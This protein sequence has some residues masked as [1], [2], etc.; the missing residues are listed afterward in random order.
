MNAIRSLLL[1]PLAASIATA[2][3]ITVLSED[4]SALTSGD[5]VTTTGAGTTWS[6][7]SNFPLVTRA[8]EAG[9]AV[10]IGTGSANGSITSLPLDLSINGG[11][12]HVSFAVKGWTTVEGDITVTVSGLPSQ[13]VSYTNVRVGSFETVGL[14]FTGGTAGSTI[15]FE[16]TSQRAYLDDIVVT[17][18]DGPPTPVISFDQATSSATESDGTLQI[19]VT[20]SI[21]GDA[22]VD[23]AVTGGDAT[24]PGDYTLL[25][26]SL[27]FSAGSPT[28]NVSLSLNDDSTPESTETIELTLSSP[29]GASLGATTHTVTVADDDSAPPSGETLVIVSANTT[30]G[31]NQQYEGP[32]DRIFQALDPD[33]VGIQEFNVPDPGGLRAWV[34]RVFGTEFHYSIEGG[35]EN[36]PCGVVS[37][38]PITASG[39]WQDP[40]VSD[41]D[42]AW[43]TIDIPGETDLHVISVH[44]HGGGG[45]S[46]RNIEAGVIVDQVQATFPA[47]DYI[48]LTGDFNTTSRTESCVTTFKTIF[49][50]AHTPVDQ[51]GDDDTNEPRNNPYDWVMPNTPLEALHTTFEFGGLSFP[52][53]FVFDTRLW[54][55][56]PSP[57]L[58][59]DSGASQMQHMAVVKA[60]QLPGA[61]P[62][63]TLGFDQATS[64]AS[65][66]DG[67]IKIPVTLSIPGS[68]TVDVSVTGGDAATPDDF[69]LLTPSLTFTSGNPTQSVSLSI[70]DDGDIESAETI[71]LT[72]SS[73]SGAALGSA[74][75]TVTITDNDS[76]SSGIFEDFEGGWD[77]PSYAGISTYDHAGVGIW[78]SQDS[79]TDTSAGRTGSAV[80]LR[81]ADAPYLEFKGLDGNGVDGGIGTVSFWFRHWNGTGAAV[82]FALEYNIADAGWVEAAT[83]NAS[84]DTYQQFSAT[85]DLSADNIRLRIRP[86]DSPP[87]ERLLIDDFEITAISPPP[88]VT[89]RGTPHA[90]LESFGFSGDFEAADLLDSDGD[91]FLNW[92]EYQ[93]GTDPT[94]STS[95]HRIENTGFSGGQFAVTCP[96][97]PDRLYAIEF[98]DT[99]DSPASWA[100]FADLSLGRFLETSATPASHTFYDDFSP[101][102]SGGQPADGRRFYRVTVEAP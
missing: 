61:P 67:T 30:S 79:L 31:N 32:G 43:A 76:V 77:D 17:S 52:S 72:L 37:R 13:T 102:T 16:T 2:A 51:G 48:V 69:T 6:G 88:A 63:P 62:A 24:S 3:P 23:V 49:S 26:S 98:T 64:A 35:N 80:R 70:A 50:D 45:P 83:G 89:S 38:Y 60:Y 9:G 36:I 87:A 97:R 74:I 75:H 53:G 71:E 73:P 44:L 10:K 41:R 47:S 12:F 42:F 28:Q 94:D 93:A 54:S 65:E 39:E 99:L 5:N 40:Q 101:L 34:D 57:A 29:T 59:N 33:I 90:W 14:D 46:S 58:T 25:T 21:P 66:S 20:L 11:S 95:L 8:Y 22:T 96:T 15:T 1:L 4:F 84:S 92:Q 100:P 19:P 81:D 27:T 82:P 78:E 56:P 85:L 86:T 18:E 91:G 55:P 7:N 68:A